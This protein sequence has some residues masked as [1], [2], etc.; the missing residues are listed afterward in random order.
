MILRNRTRMR[1]REFV[2]TVIY[3][4][5]LRLTQHTDVTLSKLK[6]ALATEEAAQLSEGQKLPHDITP[7][8]FLRMA[9]NI[10]ER[11]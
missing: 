1:N 2:S 3:S 10:E 11:Q 5:W 4:A 6:R 9:I 8:G 7:S